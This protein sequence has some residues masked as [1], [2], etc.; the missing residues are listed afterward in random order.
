MPPSERSSRQRGRQ[1]G[2]RERRGR[3]LVVSGG[4]VTESEYFDYVSRAV[5]AT[6][7][8]LVQRAEGWNPGRLVDLALKLKRE[9]AVQARR[10]KD[11]GN[12][13]SAVWV[14]VDVDD[15]AAEIKSERVR[16]T[17]LGISLV[18]S[19][20]CFEVWLVLHAIDHS[21][22]TTTAQMQ[23]I[24]RKS[25]VVKAS[26]GKSIELT[27]IRGKFSVAEQR[28]KGLLQRHQRSGSTFPD[29]NPSTTVAAVV[30]TI[31]ESADASSTNFSNP[32]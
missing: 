12:V 32:L 22:P 18:V 24:A 8:D 5:K 16:A 1:V 26:N 27:Q 14:I 7:I 6:G 3:F 13:Y 28:S 11:P 29:D 30:R 10:E 21:A 20:P 17:P 23:S 15:F 9:D 25:R 31:V 19:N 4:T 2:I